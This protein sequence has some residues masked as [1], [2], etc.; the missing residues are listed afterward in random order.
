[1]DRMLSFIVLSAMVKGSASYRIKEEG[2]ASHDTK[3][4]DAST[5]ETS[6]LQEA[7]EHDVGANMTYTIDLGSPQYFQWGESGPMFAQ[8][9]ES[10]RSKYVTG[11]ISEV[12]DMK[13]WPECANACA[14]SFYCQAWEFRVGQGQCRHFFNTN[15][16]S[17]D[18]TNG[19]QYVCGI[20]YYFAPPGTRI[21][22][23]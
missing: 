20:K 12:A 16:N 1:M 13:F 10:K 6:V 21:Y 22:A 3:E 15:V 14:H 17:Y 5:K 4:F 8:C 18:S 7:E 11:Q 23:R 9:G 19:R 2:N